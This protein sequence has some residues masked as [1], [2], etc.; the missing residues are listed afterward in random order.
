M[1]QTRMYKEEKKWKRLDFHSWFSVLYV[2]KFTLFLRT[3]CGDL[4]FYTEI[5]L[6]LFSISYAPPVLPNIQL[7]VVVLVMF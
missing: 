1:F 5:C 3:I 2:M 6:V 7:P 4:L